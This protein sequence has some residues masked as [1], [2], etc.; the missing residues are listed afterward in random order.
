MAI[1]SYIS[2][3]SLTYCI[4][5]L[6]LC[7]TNLSFALV[8]SRSENELFPMQEQDD[9]SIFLIKYL[10]NNNPRLL[11]E[12]SPYGSSLLINN[13]KQ[14]P[15]HRALITHLNWFKR[16]IRLNNPVNKRMLCFFHAVNCFV[17]HIQEEYHTLNPL[18]PC[19]DPIPVVSSL[20]KNILILF[21][22]ITGI[23]FTSTIILAILFTIEKI[24]TI[25]IKTENDL[26]VT[27]SCIKAAN[28]LLESIDESIEPCENFFQF[29]C[30]TWLKNNRIPDDTGA[31]DT[32][33]VLRNQLENH[34]VDILTSPLPNDTKQIKAIANARQLY[35]SCTDELAI[36]TAGVDTVLSVIDNELGGWPI[37]N[38]L[39]W[40]ETKFNL[41]LL[42]FKL[43]EYNNN[44][45][46]NCGTGTDDKNS[47]AYYIRIAQ[48]DLALEQRQYYLNETKLTTAYKQFIYD[49]A[50]SLTNDTTMI[51][52]DSQDIYEFEKKLSI[53]HWTTAE[54]RARQNEIIRTT[55]GNLSRIFNTSFDFTNYLRQIYRLANVTLFDNDN[56]SVSELEFLRNA[57][58]I[59]DQHSPRV[60][61]NY[62]IW[63][64]MMNRAANMPKRYRAIRE[65]FDRV[66]RGTNAERPR[67]ITCGSYVNLNMGFAVSKLYIKK[68]FDENAKNQSLEMIHNIQSVFI[69]MLEESTWMDDVSKRK[70]KEKALAIDEK[71]GYPD[72]LNSDNVTELEVDYAEYQFNTSYIHNVFKM[73]TIKSKENFKILRE[74]VDRKAWGASPP[75]VVN[76]FYTPAKNQ[77]A[78]PAGIFQMPFFHKDAP[79]YLNYGGIGAVIG[80][81]ITHGFDD[82]GRQYD[83]DGN[84]ILWWTSETIDRFNK[85]KTCIVDQYSQYILEQINISINGNQTQ[86]ENIADNGG[87]K[88][89]FYAYRKWSQKTGNIDKKLPGL[90]KYSS[91]Q[92]FFINYAQVWCSKMTDSYAMNRV[93]SGVHSPGQFRVLGP[94]SNF[95]EFDRV[96]DCKP[97]QGNS[98]VNK[99]TVW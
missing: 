67:S 76:A 89:A 1:T 16:D 24:N 41:S 56:V 88:Q 29:A 12:E 98:R 38:G 66:F 37:L 92:M 64:F 61:Q 14:S 90:M 99:C 77:I 36:E 81:E 96:F 5:I 70:A 60:I 40:N 63:R 52:K 54:Q 3:K 65:Q 11:Q 78:F 44:I 93:L 94:T 80:H 72:Y 39:S 47:S 58:L 28:Y 27:P 42:L 48:S 23:L 25:T 91:E 51:D 79:K 22:I 34:V 6:S 75:T 43:R 13:Q 50:M 21:G 95:N 8:R 2:F 19:S 18:F 84:R 20:K 31:Q 85:R 32:F 97:G 33:N 15:I 10:R 55:I 82:N 71:I 26:C 62:F 7:Q 30:G 45:I 4:L 49:L 17:A 87:I 69:E 57:S 73:L 53:F 35:D 46:Y 9:Q 86:G 59:I 83:K 68:H 74:P